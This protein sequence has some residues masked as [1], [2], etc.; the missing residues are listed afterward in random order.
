MEVGGVSLYCNYMSCII[1]KT[2]IKLCVNSFTVVATPVLQAYPQPLAAACLSQTLAISR[3]FHLHFPP[4][5]F[6]F[7]PA[8]DGWRACLLRPHQ[9]G[10]ED[11]EEGEDEVE[12][13]GERRRK[14]REEEEVEKKETQS[15]NTPLILILNTAP[16]QYIADD[17]INMNILPIP[18]NKLIYTPHVRLLL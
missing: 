2:K 16:T 15:I 4:N 5:P 12:K 14:G 1:L 17:N 18:H 8:C 7:E 6:P 13:R 3:H 9:H 11:K 10:S